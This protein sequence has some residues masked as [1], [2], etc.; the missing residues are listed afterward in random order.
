MFQVLLPLLLLAAC[1]GSVT[2]DDLPQLPPNDDD[3]APADDDD[4]DDDDAGDDDLQPD[5]DDVQPDDDDTTPFD[6]PEPVIACQAVAAI[7]D[8]DPPHPAP[9]EPLGVT[10]TAATGY[11]W[12]GMEVTGPGGH[13]QVGEVAIS[14][15]GPFTWAWVY[16]LEAEGWY[17]F[18]FTADSGATPI[19]EGSVYVSG[20]PAGDDDDVQPDDD[21][22]TPDA[23]P[24]N[25]FGIGLVG[26]G[27]PGQWDLASE[28]AGPGGHVKLIFPGILPSTSGPQA[29]QVAAVQ[30]A[31]D[32]D[33]VPVI[34]LGPPW[35]QRNIRAWSDD[36]AHLDYTSL[37]ATWAA[38]V[39]GLPMRDGWPLW[40][41]V[42]NEPNLCYE[43]EC[44]PADGWLGSAVRA[45][46]YAAFLRDVTSAIQALGDPRIGVINGGLAPGGAVTC[47]CGGS[48]FTAGETSLDFIAAMEA[49]EPGVFADLDGFAT[50]SYPSSGGGW[51]FFPA[52]ADSGT[53]LWWWQQEVAAAGVA[54]KPVFVTETGWTVNAGA[55]GSRQEVADWTLL[56]W[57][58]DWLPAVE[59]EAVMPFQLQDPA[60]DDFGWVESGGAHYPVF[61]AIRD[62]RCSMAFP[63]PC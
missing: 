26:P 32:R 14:G 46:E 41:E 8:F 58:N 42:H 3:S 33:L 23:P 49:A 2:D 7:M 11:V 59:L 16:L 51:G 40:V 35:G 29:D 55:F 36:A 54:G 47:E 56:A 19:C 6:P 17:S 25:P 13:D 61:D 15:S 48:G 62:W 18:T 21:D 10:V 63:G 5:D 45:A 4:L 27:N 24:D 60:W 44:D 1:Y 39:A 12:I 38:V 52:Y 22:A 34:R 37:A 20:D 30:G 9:G 53:G 50:H 43:W 57:Q 28:L 31:W